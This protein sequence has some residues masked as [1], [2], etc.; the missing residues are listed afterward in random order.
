MKLFIN[1]WDGNR[2]TFV[3]GTEEN[4]EYSV[5]KWITTKEGKRIYLASV[6]VYDEFVMFFYIYVIDMMREYIEHT[7]YE[8]PKTNRDWAQQ[9]GGRSYFSSFEYEVNHLKSKQGS[10][11]GCLPTQMPDNI[12]AEKMDELTKMHYEEYDYLLGLMKGRL[13]TELKGVTLAFRKDCYAFDE[14]IN[15][16][17]NFAVFPNSYEASYHF[18][19]KTFTMPFGNSN[20]KIEYPVGNTQSY[21]ILRE[22]KVYDMLDTFEE[23]YEEFEKAHKNALQDLEKRE[24]PVN[25]DVISMDDLRTFY[26]KRLLL[27]SYLA[28]EEHRSYDFYLKEYLDAVVDNSPSS[29]GRIWFYNIDVD[30]RLENGLY[31]HN[32]VLCEMNEKPKAEYEITLMWAID[33]VQHER[34]AVFEMKI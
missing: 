6:Y 2:D 23:Q 7:T 21:V 28:P 29:S 5:N 31:K 4:R 8:M 1:D 33:S 22:L 13:P 17:K 15:E 18:I 26:D 10:S 27:L 16:I 3:I 9:S 14:P 19:D 34:K 11:G 20:I 32:A 30:D 25:E 24:N 12:P